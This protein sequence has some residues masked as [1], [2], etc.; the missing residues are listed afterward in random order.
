MKKKMMIVLIL[1][2]L[3]G[4]ALAQLAPPCSRCS[5]NGKCW[6]CSGTGT[7]SSAACYMCNGTGKC[8]YCG[9]RGTTSCA[10]EHHHE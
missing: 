5:G 2:A 1:I 9:G 3:A 4:S 8:W 6:T 7:S 10:P